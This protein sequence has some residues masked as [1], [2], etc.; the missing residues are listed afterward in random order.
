VNAE[1]E[2]IDQGLNIK[3]SEDTTSIMKYIIL[4]EK[5]T[6]LIQCLSDQKGSSSKPNQEEKEQKKISIPLSRTK[7][8][9]KE[10]EQPIRKL[11]D[12]L[13]STLNFLNRKR[14]GSIQQQTFNAQHAPI[15]QSAFTGQH[16]P[17]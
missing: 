11:T 9:T 17:K 10:L 1:K 13:T 16:I 8:D 15:F 2:M 5:I 6:D 7:S 3:F 4:K 14:Y 12:T